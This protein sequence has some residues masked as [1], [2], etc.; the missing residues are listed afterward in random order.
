MFEEEI[1]NIEQKVE[2]FESKLFRFEDKIMMLDCKFSDKN[3]DVQREVQVL[4]NSKEKDKEV[5]LAELKDNLTNITT[6]FEEQFVEISKQYEKKVDSSEKISSIERRFSLKLNDADKCENSVIT[7]ENKISCVAMNLKQI[8]DKILHFDKEIKEINERKVR[9]KNSS[10]KCDH[11]DQIFDKQSDLENHMTDIG[12]EENHK[13]TQCES[14][15]LTK[16][17]LKKHEKIHCTTKRRRNCHYFNSGKSCPYEKLGCKFKHCYSE[18][19]NF[20]Q[21]CRFTMCQFKHF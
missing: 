9:L 20:G 1:E 4:K 12:I 14:V 15:F 16:W 5:G 18:P 2:Q 13:C 11:C 7:L 6:K 19:C 17:R 10:K 8:D 21:S 3:K